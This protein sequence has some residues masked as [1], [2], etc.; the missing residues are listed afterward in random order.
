MQEIDESQGKKETELPDGN[1]ITVGSERFR[2]PEIWFQPSFLG[3]KPS[4]HHDT[5]FHSIMKCGVG[6]RKNVYA[7]IVNS[8]WNY[9]GHRDWWVHDHGL[10][11]FRF[12]I[13]ENQGVHNTRR[14]YSVW[15]GPI[16]L[17]SALS[18]KCGYRKA[19]M[20]RVALPLFTENVSQNCKC[21]LLVGCSQCP[22]DVFQHPRIWNIIAMAGTFIFNAAIQLLMNV[23]IITFFQTNQS[24]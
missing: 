13:H 20:T 5:T 4:G 23:A 9:H 7:N 16:R 21:M 22:I 11:S 8:W 17:R 15:I 24:S 1:I 6:F 2:C 3:K 18:N 10:D 19:S 12:I 14:E